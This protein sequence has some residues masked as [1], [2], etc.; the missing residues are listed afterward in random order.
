MTIES[1]NGEIV[2]LI[3][4]LPG[5]Y[6]TD[7]TY[8]GMIGE[9]YRLRVITENGNEYLSTKETLNEAPPIDSLYGRY[10]QLPSKE[11][12]AILNG[13]QIFLVTD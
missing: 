12:G 3:E 10:V 4:S 2:N 7:S 8:A 5:N 11:S 13:V 6:V 1:E 9:S